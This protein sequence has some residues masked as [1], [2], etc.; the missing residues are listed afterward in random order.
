MGIINPL[1][2]FEFNKKPKDFTGTVIGLPRALHMYEYF[3]FVK[4][5]VEGSDVGKPRSPLSRPA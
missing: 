1:D 4:T 3:P 2:L 5:I